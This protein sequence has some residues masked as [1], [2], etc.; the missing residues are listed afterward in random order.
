MYGT[1]DP[2]E[3]LEEGSGLLASARSLRAQ[4][5]IVRRQLRNRGG[6]RIHPF[7]SHSRSHHQ[8][9]IKLTSLPRASMLL[10]GYA[11]EMNL[12][13][14]LVKI[15][16]GCSLGMID[17][18]VKAFGHKF[19]SIAEAIC[20]P[21]SPEIKCQLH[22]LEKCVLIHARYPIPMSSKVD[23]SS[24]IDLAA[25]YVDEVKLRN[26]NIW[27]SSKKF[28]ELCGLIR[29]IRMHLQKI[30]GDDENPESFRKE[31]LRPG[32]YL[33]LRYGGNLPGRITY[34]AEEGRETD[35]TLDDIRQLA[36]DF[37]WIEAI[38]YWD[39]FLIV[40]DGIKKTKKLRS[41]RRITTCK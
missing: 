40:E 25:V 38:H 37:G 11:A 9:M 27:N 39:K 3:W 34:R 30:D 5:L 31:W 35:R 6:E 14:G 2:N 32:G 41:P 16:D 21:T 33:V 13:A 12:K 26:K 24:E 7:G 10:L 18:E 20:Y 8:L 22:M 19:V 4:W 29:S 15:Y 23:V 28:S 17:R 1:Y 36:I